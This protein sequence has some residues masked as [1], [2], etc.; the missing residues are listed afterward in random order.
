MIGLPCVGPLLGFGEWRI[1][2]HKGTMLELKNRYHRL[3]L[4][5]G[6]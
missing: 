5:L 6:S 3:D 1:V 4:E 2:S